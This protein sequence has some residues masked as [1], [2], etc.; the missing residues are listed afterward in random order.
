MVKDG[1]FKFVMVELARH[2]PYSIFGVTIGLL[3]M[4]VLTFL[5]ILVRAEGLL[6]YAS[7]EVFHVFHPA[8][9]LISAVASTA[10][11]W[12][13]EKR[14]FKAALVGFLGSITICAISD[15][16]LPYI[17]GMLTGKP[18]LMH[19]CI[20]EEPGLVYP[21]AVVGV[22][23]GLMVTNNFERST[24]YTHSAHVFISSAAS[25]LYLLGYGLTDWI[26]SVGSVF[27]I[28][29]A[30]VMIPCCASDIV[31]PLAC[32]HRNCD[33]PDELEHHY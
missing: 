31:F 32:V 17:G 15:I 18:M 2:M 22:L 13:H 4:G 26:H 20:I 8:H 16:F 14:I 21:F 33:H 3:A 12:K 28:I 25:L 11:F 24:Q 6:G 30:A 29:I 1:K 9:I 5:A 7:Q 23:A 27:L 10:M 19:V